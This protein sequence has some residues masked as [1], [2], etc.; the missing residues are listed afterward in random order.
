MKGLYKAAEW[1]QISAVFSGA[2]QFMK[3]ARKKD[4]RWNA[5]IGSGLGTASLNLKEG[6]IGRHCTVLY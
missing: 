4:D 5:Y 2:E 3:V 1:G 6:P